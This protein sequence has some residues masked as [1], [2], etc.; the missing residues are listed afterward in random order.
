MDGV[1]VN[2]TMVSEP[3]DIKF[4]EGITIKPRFCTKAKPLLLRY[5]VEAD[6]MI[7]EMLK[8]GVIGKFDGY[9]E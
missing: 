6:R 1:P 9:S 4:K 2:H 7:E 8:A 3:V 5:K